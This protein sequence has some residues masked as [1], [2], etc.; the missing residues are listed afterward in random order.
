MT[1]GWNLPKQAE[2]EEWERYVHYNC[3]G[4]SHLSI[5]Y[6]LLVPEEADTAESDTM[7]KVSLADDVTNDCL[8]SEGNVSDT[9][10]L[11]FYESPAAY[12]IPDGAWHEIVL[13]FTDDYWT[14]LSSDDTD[15][16]DLARLSAWNIEIS[17]NSGFVSLLQV[18]HL[19]CVS[20][21][22]T[23]LDR[24][25]R[26]NNAEPTETFPNDEWSNYH[27][28][29]EQSEENT[30]QILQNDGLSWDVSLSCCFC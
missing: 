12:L 4:S 1:F 13:P 6:K 7:L 23:L 17:D 3:W 25:L 28:N 27:F 19:S 29:S 9:W 11:D 16:M 5:W 10:C 15:M 22:K 30:E 8:N 18:D 14:G 2:L 24:L 20:D 21:G 26:P